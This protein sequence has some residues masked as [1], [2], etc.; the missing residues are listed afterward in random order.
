MDFLDF[1]NKKYSPTEWRD[2]YKSE[3][4]SLLSQDAFV[5]SKEKMEEI[6]ITL[7]SHLFPVF[8]NKVGRNYEVRTMNELR[9]NNRIGHPDKFDRYFHLSLDNI[10]FTKSQIEHMLQRAEKEELKAF[11][12]KQDGTESAYDFLEEVYARLTILPIDRVLCIIGALVE[13]ASS[14]KSASFRKFWSSDTSRLAYILTLDLIERI[15][16]DKRLQC[17]CDI[18][19]TANLT[20]LEALANIINIIELCYGRLA[21]NGEERGDKRVITIE[22]LLSLEEQFSN[23]T[24]FLLDSEKSYLFDGHSMILYLLEHFAPDYVSAYLSKY[25]ENDTKV[26]NFLLHTI[27][28]L[29]GDGVL[30]EVKKDYQK[31]MTNERVLNAINSQ[32]KI[33]DFF[34][35]PERTQIYSAVFCLHAMCKSDNFGY[36]HQEDV[37]DLLNEWKNEALD[38]VFINI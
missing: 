30:Y 23:R 25:F 21:A 12:M 13:V 19:E 3:L 22:E 9:K 35:L 26:L 29:T 15:E 1:S 4:V 36:I 14:F 8:G 5:V 33:G 7:L 2:L 27:N 10:A 11:L 24:K 32:K 16:P 20:T 18:L 38:K 6:I 17:I 34:A 28:V 37:D 31:Y